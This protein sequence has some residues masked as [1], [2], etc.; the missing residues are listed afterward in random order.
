MGII[1]NEIR[2]RKDNTKGIVQKI[3]TIM[4]NKKKCDKCGEMGFHHFQDPKG[5]NKRYCGGCYLEERELLRKMTCKHKPLEDLDLYDFSV[6]QTVACTD[7]WKEFKVRLV[8]SSGLTPKKKLRAKDVLR[9]TD[10]LR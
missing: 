4:N 1:R 9:E 6:N 7:C 5:K 8:V 3:Q 2:K 10:S